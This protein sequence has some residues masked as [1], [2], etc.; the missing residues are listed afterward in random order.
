MPT[1]VLQ[2]RVTDDGSARVVAG[3]LDRVGKAGGKATSSV[4][5]LT[6]ALAGIGVAATLRAIASVNDRFAELDSAI[7]T[8]V[9]NV[10][11]ANAIMGELAEVAARTRSPLAGVVGTFDTLQDATERLNL[12]T[13]RLIGLTETWTKLFRIGG[14]SA[15]AAASSVQQLGASLA[16][17]DF[18]RGVQTLLRQN[19]DFANAIA[20][21]YGV[22]VDELRNLAKEGRLTSE[23]FIAATEQIRGA[24]DE[25]FGFV[26]GT[27]GQALT[28]LNDST[29][30]LVRR[31]FE[32]TEAG[33]AIVG[34]IDTVS[35]AM[36]DLAGNKEALA[37]FS[38]TVASGFRA[39][40]AT[41]TQVLAVIVGVSKAG[42]VIAKKGGLAN[43][44][45][46]G[47]SRAD[48]QAIFDETRDIIRQARDIDEN[49]VFRR[50]TAPPGAAPAPASGASGG[51]LSPLSLLGAGR[52]AEAAAARELEAAA[53]AAD[54][55]REAFA[56]LRGEYDPLVAAGQKY[57]EVL[58]TVNEALRLGNAGQSEAVAVLQSATAELDRARNAA[59]VAALE[60]F[61]R[62]RAS[63][64]PAAAAGMQ[65]AATVREI[66][67]AL[68]A[69]PELQG[70]AVE[71]LQLATDRYT[72]AREELAG[73]GKGGTDVFGAIAGQ[74]DSALN[75]VVDFANGG[76]ASIGDFA[77]SAVADLQR[78]FLQML[79]VKSFE[80]L[81]GAFGGASGG[82]LGGAFG[83]LAKSFGGG[84]ASGGPVGPG[85]AFLVGEEG[86]ELFVP[87]G[88]GNIIANDALTGG[89]RGA[90]VNQTIEIDPMRFVDVMQTREA[91]GV[92]LNI[93][94][95]NRGKLREFVG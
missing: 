34:T 51:S 36:R 60:G 48:L 64:D 24:V 94:Q 41:A 57:S 77:R 91:E 39:I 65:Y 87:P 1:E 89:G 56:R 67:A 72:K 28:T 55:N 47:D 84:M 9:G 15:G 38:Q 6:G 49:S 44:L 76:A 54:A 42:A 78:V 37:G 23:S 12:E 70:Q 63:L 93:I 45:I 79:L 14:Q 22:G 4:R 26:E 58:A 8:N 35:K 2:I 10:G 83:L 11:Q 88:R 74:F 32:T 92:V 62:L 71:L 50:P 86:P 19:L 25:N 18:S 82:G 16:S 46:F 3:N 90:V 66:N 21:G 95:R 27:I 69:N 52:G 85:K 61:E 43:A 40:E 59:K 53:R 17:N 30:L 7:R 81:S 29:G 73:K 80:G 68:A 31:F 20:K 75:S 5:L 13:P 33:G